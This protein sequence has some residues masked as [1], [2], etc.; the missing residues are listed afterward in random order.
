[1][2]TFEQLLRKE[3]YQKGVDEGRCGGIKE[4][5]QQ[6]QREL[7]LRQ[8]T[9]RFGSLPPDSASRVAGAGRN[10]LERWSDRILDAASL[11]DVFA[12]S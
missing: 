9:R 7:V 10:E 11:D 4:G 3:E 1:M 8:L 2:L 5:V 12:A 6:G